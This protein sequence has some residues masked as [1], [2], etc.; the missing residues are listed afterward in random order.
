M[1]KPREVSDSQLRLTFDQATRAA[2]PVQHSNVVS[3]K[4]A[5]RHALPS[6]AGTER[7]ALEKILLHAQNLKRQL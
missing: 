6:S 1:R 3:L 4:S 2:A 5:V 7:A